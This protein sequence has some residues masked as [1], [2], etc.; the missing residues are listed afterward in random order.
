MFQ[1]LGGK[2]AVKFIDLPFRQYSDSRQILLHYA[3]RSEDTASALFDEAAT[4]S[5]SCAA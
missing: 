5:S 3:C 2:S 4:T 1:D